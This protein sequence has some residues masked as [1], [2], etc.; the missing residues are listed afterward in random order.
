MLFRSDGK[1]MGED[2]TNPRIAASKAADKLLAVRGID[3]SFAL[4]KIDTGVS[5]SARSGDRINVQLIMEKLGGGG[6]FD[7]AGAQI[8]NT[9]LK[10]ACELLKTAI[11]EYLESQQE[12]KKA[13]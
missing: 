8:N 13:N 12:I 3:A 2:H 4:I 7:M 10:Q 1:Q 5:I 9:S 6:H 11:D